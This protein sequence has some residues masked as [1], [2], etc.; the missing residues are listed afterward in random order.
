MMR[1]LLAGVAAAAVLSLVLLA[2]SAT[3]DDHEA[4]DQPRQYIEW[5]TYR[6]KNEQQFEAVDAY[7]RDALLPALGRLEIGPVGVFEERDSE[8]AASDLHLLIPY[9]TIE[10]FATLNATL[11]ADATYQAAARDFFDTPMNEPRYRRIESELLYAFDSFPQVHVPAEK[12][13]GESRLFELRIYE[14]HNQHKG[15]VKVD[16]FDEG[17]TEIF[18]DVG[19]QP[20]FMGQAI[21]GPY[22]PN[23][24]YL[25]VYPDAEARDKAWEKFLAHPDWETLSQMEKYAE[26][27]SNIHQVFLLPRP[28]SQL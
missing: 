11:Q 1:S 10:Q 14:S 17:E 25:A 21:A 24:T 13:A 12:K 26:T 16:M 3:A 20:V 23:L 5:R 28:Y 19:V 9:D 2:P 18:L 4:A 27:V 6:L 15:D 7:L 22:M 8:D